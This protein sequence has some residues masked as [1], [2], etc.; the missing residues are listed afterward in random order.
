MPF[1]SK[2]MQTFVTEGLQNSI[3]FFRV[4]LKNKFKLPWINC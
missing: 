2:F 1:F 3:P 4:Y